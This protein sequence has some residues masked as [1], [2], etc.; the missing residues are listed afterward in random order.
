[1]NT[2]TIEIP[3]EVLI[4]L[5]ETPETLSRELSM[6][7]AVK[8][9]ELGKLSSGRAAQLAQLSRVEFLNLIGRYQVSPFT[10]SPE[11]LEQDVLN[12]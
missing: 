9:F 5:K 10:L 8:L 11:E 6:L 3:E 7:A 1:M 2:V 12:A 4:S